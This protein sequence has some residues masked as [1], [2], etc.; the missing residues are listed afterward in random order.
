M[1]LGEK[2][3]VRFNRCSGVWC[4]VLAVAPVHSFPSIRGKGGH[5]SGRE[6]GQVT[7]GGKATSGI[8]IHS[9]ITL[10]SSHNRKAPKIEENSKTSE[11]ST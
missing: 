11:D 4:L 2:W 6:A 1:V 7:I 5:Q 9:L 3:K 8:C 10:H